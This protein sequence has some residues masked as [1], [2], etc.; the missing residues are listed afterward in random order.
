M[1][2]D[3]VIAIVLGGITMMIPIVAILTYHQRK[4]AEIIHRE[5]GTSDP[6]LL[7]EVVRLREELDRV[8]QGMYETSI[9][10]DDLRAPKPPMASA[11]ER[12]EE[13]IGGQ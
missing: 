7:E 4:M 10:L 5:R 11:P 12:L 2:G 1:G 6:R 9:A 8:K 13:R 3:E